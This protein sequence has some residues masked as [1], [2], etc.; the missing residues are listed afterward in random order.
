MWSPDVYRQPFGAM[1]AAMQL[2]NSGRARTLSDQLMAG[3]AAALAEQQQKTEQEGQRFGWEEQAH[4]AMMGLPDTA[5]NDQM[6]RTYI[7]SGGD[8]ARALPWMRAETTASSRLDVA[9]LRALSS[10]LQEARNKGATPEQQE[11][12]IRS[13]RKADG[14]GYSEDQ[15]AQIKSFPGMFPQ[16]TANIG[17]TEAQGDVATA[18]AGAIPQ[19]TEETARHDKAMEGIAAAREN[20]IA[21]LRA[22]GIFT[23]NEEK[24][25]RA[26]MSTLDQRIATLGGKEGRV[27]PNT[28]IKYK[29]NPHEQ[30]SLEAYKRERGKVQAILDENDRRKM[31]QSSGV[32]PATTTPGEDP[33]DPLGIFSKPQ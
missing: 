12:I 27:D 13:H 29:L 20:G 31:G 8:L 23:P 11:S 25:Y 1:S 14:S 2:Y 4:N 30:A 26:M 5:T 6:I 18:T 17:K 16:V 22:G 21:K 3:R 28:F 32:T 24:G 33:T 7:K 15:I 9:D 10:E 19:R